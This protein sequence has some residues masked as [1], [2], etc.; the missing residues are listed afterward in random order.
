MF[1]PLEDVIDFILNF[2][3]LVHIVEN[4]SRFGDLEDIANLNGSLYEHSNFTIKTF[5]RINSMRKRA[6]VEE[7]VSVKNATAN[8]T[9]H[10]AI[11][12]YESR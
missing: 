1:G 2:H 9:E 12:T 4:V 10:I 6:T 7:A 8:V 11:W 3:M 5:I